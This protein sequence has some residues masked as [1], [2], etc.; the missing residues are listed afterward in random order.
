MFPPD[1][2]VIVG[3]ICPGYRVAAIN[4]RRVPTL[5]YDCSQ[6]GHCADVLLTLEPLAVIEGDVVDQNGM[7]VEQIRLELQ[8]ARGG[9][10]SRRFNA[11]SDDRGYF[12]LFH[13][14]PGKYELR[15]A[16]RGSVHRG[17]AWEGD[18]Q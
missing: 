18:S 4:G 8:R 16:I 13:L 6:P 9:E 14:P 12:R 5:T 17:V 11:V 1:S 2:R 3:T 15:P 10:R 7:P